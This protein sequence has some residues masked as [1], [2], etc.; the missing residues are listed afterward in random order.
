MRTGDFG[1][2]ISGLRYK[3]C[4]GQHAKWV[5]QHGVSLA[6]KRMVKR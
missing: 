4:F 3:Y 2:V 1:V 5:K 6:A